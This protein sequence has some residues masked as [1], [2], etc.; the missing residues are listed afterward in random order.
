MDIE[1]YEG[2]VDFTGWNF[3]FEEVYES[4]IDNIKKYLDNNHL[5]EEIEKEIK[6]AFNESVIETLKEDPPHVSI[7]IE[8]CEYVL[9]FSLCFGECELSGPWF[10]VKLIDLFAERFHD[11]GNDGYENFIKQLSDLAKKG[12]QNDT[13]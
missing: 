1:H 7:G 12:E 6:H 3:D 11:C 4:I 8:D 13:H 5:R 2:E 10:K 9:Y